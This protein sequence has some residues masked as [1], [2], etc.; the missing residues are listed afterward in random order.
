MSVH[1][2]GVSI[3][4]QREASVRRGSRKDARFIYLL[5]LVVLMAFLAVSIYLWSRLKVVDL[6]YEI[7]KLNEA[8]ASL[9]E[10]NK[11]FRFELMELKSPARIEKMARE[12]GLSYPKGEQVV[13]IE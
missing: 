10:T 2:T 1:L 13:H 4:G 6:G 5:P 9:L 12:T 11:R 8:R 3:F 7:S